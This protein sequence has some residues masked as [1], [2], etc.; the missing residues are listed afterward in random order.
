MVWI[1]RTLTI[2]FILVLLYQQ[3][4]CRAS[5]DN[6]E[7]DSQ[8]EWVVYSTEIG[9]LRIGTYSEYKAFWQKKD[10]L[11]GGASTDTLKKTLLLQ[12][13]SSWNEAADV[14]CSKLA[15]VQIH[16]NPPLR[17]APSR[18]MTALFDTTEFYLRLT[19]GFS[20][21]DVVIMSKG[22]HFK[23]LEYNWQTEWD[24]LMANNITPRYIF[25][26]KQWL[27]HVT[28]RGTRQGHQ[29]LDSW[30][31][32]TREPDEN[33]KFTIP[34][35]NGT[36]QG[37]QCDN[38]EGPFLDSYTL[39]EV[40][41]R[42]DIKTIDL[43]PPVKSRIGRDVQ[44]GV[45]AEKIPKNPKDYGDDVL[46]Q[47]PIL[48]D[49]TFEDWVIYEVEGGWL[50]VGTRHEFKTPLLKR[51]VVWGG[52]SDEEAKKILLAPLNEEKYFS[53]EQALKNLCA[54][55]TELTASYHPGAQPKE[56][57]DCKYD[58]K[59][60][61]LRIDRG[62]N[63]DRVLVHNFKNYDYWGIWNKL[64]E[65][66]ITPRRN[67]SPSK[68]VH[69]TGY[70][71]YSGPQKSDSWR[72]V[73]AS[74][75]A[76]DGKSMRLADGLG[77]TMG[78]NIDFASKEL[79]S[80]YDLSPVL[81]SLIGSDKKLKSKLSSLGTRS[82]YHGIRPDEVPDNAKDYGTEPKASDI[83]I[84]EIIPPEAYQGD[85][86]G[87]TLIAKGIDKGCELDFG[88]SI[89]I[90]NLVYGGRSAIDDFDL[91]YCTLIINDIAE[92]GLRTVTSM[93]I[94]GGLF[95]LQEGFEVSEQPIELCPFIKLITPT[96]ADNPYSAADCGVYKADQEKAIKKMKLIA[97]KNTGLSA[98]NERD[99]K[100]R[101]IWQEL[102]DARIEMEVAE[103]FYWEGISKLI[104]DLSDQQL[105]I[106]T[107]SLENRC[108]CLLEKSQ[109][110]LDILRETTFS[111]FED[112]P[113]YDRESEYRDTYKA[114]NHTLKLWRSFAAMLQERREYNIQMARRMKT[115]GENAEL[116]SAQRKLCDAH[117]MKGE[118]SL[119]QEQISIEYG[120]QMKDSHGAS[121]RQAT[122]KREQIKI[123]DDKGTAFYQWFCISGRYFVGV[124]QTMF[125]GAFGL[126]QST[127][128]MLFSDWYEAESMSVKIRE[129]IK[130]SRERF[131]LKQDQMRELRNL[132]E[133][134]MLAFGEQ[135][136]EEGI[137]N[138]D[139]D[140]TIL[141]ESRIWVEDTDGGFL[142][143]RA[144]YDNTYQQLRES[145][146]R[147]MLRRAEL[148]LKDM[149]ETLNIKM[150]A[151]PE[152]G[153]FD[154]IKMLFEPMKIVNNYFAES[155][156]A[157]F[158]SRIAFLGEREAELKM[159]KQMLPALAKIDF[160]LKRLKWYPKLMVNH[161]CLEAKNPNY[162]R[163]CIQMKAIDSKLNEDLLEKN[164]LDARTSIRVHEIKRKRFENRSSTMKLMG[165]DWA[166]WCK[167]DG[168]ERLMMWDWQGAI[169]SFTQ[170]SK[171]NPEIIKPEAVENLKK[172]LD[173][174]ISTEMGLETF[175]FLGNQGF[176]SMVF[177]FAG[178]LGGEALHK[179]GFN[180]WGMGSIDD[181]ALAA[182]EAQGFWGRSM[183]YWSGF[184]D[185]T[186][187][188]INPFW[189]MATAQGTWKEVRTK[190][191]QTLEEVM[192]EVASPE[193][194]YML[195]YF[196]M[197]KEYADFIAE[198]LVE[199]YGGVK[200]TNK[201]LALHDALGLNSNKSKWQRLSVM[202][203]LFT[204][205]ANL[206]SDLARDLI[207]IEALMKAEKSKAEFEL[208]LARETLMDWDFNR[209]QP[210]AEEIQEAE[211]EVNNQIEAIS[212]ERI[213]TALSDLKQQL[214]QA[215]T[216][217]ERIELLSKFFKDVSFNSQREQFEDNVQDEVCILSDNY[218][219]EILDIIRHQFLAQ[220]SEKYSRFFIGYTIYGSAAH[221]EW[222]A[223]KRLW[224]DLD[225]TALLKETT[226]KEIRD[227]F[228]QDFD[229]FFTDKA[230]MP[231]EALDIHM[232]AD[233]KPVFR[234]R[235]PAS[236]L[237]EGTA[238]SRA[239]SENPELVQ[240]IYD[241]STE[242][243]K[244]L[245]QNMVDPER[246]L[247][248]GNL[249]VF[250]YLVKM[251]GIMQ[252]GEL[253]K[254]G[255]HYQLKSDLSRFSEVYENVQFD[256]WMGL[257]ILLDHLIHISHARESNISD[258]YA[259]SK[260][261]AKYSMRILLGRIIQTS[262]GIRLLNEATSDK[263]AE[264]GGLEAYIV[265]VAKELTSSYG[266]A[267]LGLTPSQLKLLD[268]WVKRKEAKPF[269]E[270]FQARAEAGAPLSD[271]DSNMDKYISD[272]IN[273]TETFLKESIGF[274]IASQA[275]F[276][277]QLMTE[278]EMEQDPAKQ[279][280]LQAKFRQIVC[281]QAA[282]WQRLQPSE[283]KLVQ[284][285]APEN[286]PFWK[287]I[288]L[289]NNIEIMAADQ[290]GDINT[291]VIET[292]WPKYI[293]AGD[294]EPQVP[295]FPDI[296]HLFNQKVRVIL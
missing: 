141:E 206:R 189:N 251:V 59:E 180:W 127:W 8:K 7:G 245:W 1:N 109:D 145:E 147:I 296:N 235:I 294:K 265:Q 234:A 278:A 280:A 51:D 246:Y 153:E 230:K 268:E 200:Q 24:S 131:I 236:V 271:K 107:R 137:D 208:M 201:S 146:Y 275:T 257:D 274:T 104:G 112:S 172:D 240:K 85:T 270:I 151:D 295:A 77:G 164:L 197:D 214:E 41:K 283:R 171:S 260:D 249:F 57:I 227:Q 125:S 174:Q 191:L 190:Y 242:N 23:G 161:Y 42:Y 28:G 49:S 21:G 192:E 69:V 226:P 87:I 160:D 110:R 84:K 237:A 163:W 25:P 130:E 247:L 70:Y 19:K 2:L 155:K 176:Y 264:A 129:Q 15:K 187:G 255:D 116:L 289:Y 168:I 133:L 27:I 244:L 11:W 212:K 281:S 114:L 82:L 248:P 193:V 211:T 156:R 272:H 38:Y 52:T 65:Y 36:T 238:L 63:G 18:Y 228:K 61:R 48:P 119:I 217:D 62:A 210:K 121:L 178:K 120:M 90:K 96:S 216:L 67:F 291:F 39:A 88:D 123:S 175:E 150:G 259:Y 43:W 225:I 14:L 185:F 218:R 199:S 44:P 22:G 282:L 32:F 33:G 92:A 20:E 219:R 207:T 169:M 195:G 179:A 138:M 243:L 46:P 215:N 267:Y 142:R 261:L 134:G 229:N 99:Q 182:Q 95:S 37:Y 60:Y 128:N 250:N 209:L 273:E 126:L 100:K 68:L 188:Q 284:L 115:L 136:R 94:D 76:A 181:L 132:D 186:F 89:K 117:L 55:L 71:T 173:W 266:S 158:S 53:L 276:L 50:H 292:W 66:E 222:A 143:L 224:S 154:R 81:R 269:G 103:D 78:Y 3:A 288:E 12:G 205:R 122:Q 73:P 233:T 64:S 83:S 79:K 98:G 72:L 279:R 263:V 277:I 58:G 113:Y 35:A 4:I 286:S 177:G 74:A 290:N 40:M 194:S 241:E 17:G 26:S 93:N 198:A 54:N 108:N 149:N 170:A 183:K 162:L 287:I 239:L 135:I 166:R 105:R 262:Q 102:Q 221:P 124:N 91:W 220:F 202:H 106:I 167:M 159:A 293:L 111:F 139:D 31:C 223:Y 101:E 34:L 258:M 45:N 56:T 29:E 16:I 97:E 213:E 165:T 157:E 47:Q 256:S 80:N 144:C 6:F 13:F 196:G 5:E 204:E 118:I 140:I 30:M 10:E 254:E 253:V 285:M 232:F 184:A 75:I 252:T 86:L 152:S 231:P 9:W 148:S 203:K